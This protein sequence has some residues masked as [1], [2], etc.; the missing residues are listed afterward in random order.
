MKNHGID[1]SQ[2]SCE[3]QESQ[4]RPNY[5]AELSLRP[6]IVH[7]MTLGHKIK[8]QHQRNDK[9]VLATKETLAKVTKDR[10]IAS[11][12]VKTT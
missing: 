5:E 2:G 8:E 4:E 7:V 11:S 6:L 9:R 3:S 12:F 1:E 10:Q